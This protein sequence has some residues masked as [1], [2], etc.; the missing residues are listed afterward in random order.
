MGDLNAEVRSAEEQLHR[1]QSSRQDPLQAFG[2]W[3]GHLVT[4]LRQNAHHFHKPPKGPLGAMIKLKDYKWA[5]AVECVLGFGTLA[6]FIVDN[7]EDGRTFK[8]IMRKV[9]RSNNFKPD[10]IATRFEVG[11]GRGGGVGGGRGGGVGAGRGGGVGG[12][13]GV[14]VGAGRGGL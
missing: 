4:A 8:S 12:G 11:A 2:A 7:Q 10:A 9:L 5:R 6:A 1:L 14:E 13:R 3:M